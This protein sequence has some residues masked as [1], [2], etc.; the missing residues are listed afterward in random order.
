VHFVTGGA[1]NG[2]ATWVKEFYQINEQKQCCWLSGYRD[3]QWEKIEER[4]IGDLVVLEGIEQWLKTISKEDGTELGRE[5]WRKALGSW[6]LWEKEGRHL[7]IIGTDI[8]KGIVPI[9]AADRVWRDL[10]G[11]AYQ[12][13]A[14]DSTRVDVI[15]YGIHTRLK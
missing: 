2:K 13:V 15:W 9:E 12:D 11:W 6:L 3:A 8:S 14:K 5:K 10:T 4:F 7:V 1:F